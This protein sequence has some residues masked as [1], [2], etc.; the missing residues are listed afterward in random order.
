MSSIFTFRQN[1]RN[2]FADK[3]KK[4]KESYFLDKCIVMRNS[5]LYDINK[6]EIFEGDIIEIPAYFR[7]DLKR[8]KNNQIIIPEGVKPIDEIITKVIF[9][10]GRFQPTSEPNALLSQAHATKNKVKVIGNVHE[11]P[12]LLN[13]V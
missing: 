2:V 13:T 6:V 12:N 1:Q 9:K 10:E 11:H 3:K 7:S 8:N 5:E 4:I